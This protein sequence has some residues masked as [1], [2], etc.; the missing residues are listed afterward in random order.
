MLSTVF[1]PAVGCAIDQHGGRGILAISNL[2]LCRGLVLL[3]LSDGILLLA[4]A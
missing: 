3:G 4:L 1:G 2:V